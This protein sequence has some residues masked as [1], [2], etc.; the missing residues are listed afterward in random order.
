ML[1]RLAT[2]SDPQIDPTPISESRLPYVSGPRWK[3]S[4]TNTGIYVRIGMLRKVI[5]NAR[6][7]RPTID[8][9]TPD[10]A[11]ALLE[12]VVHRFLGASRA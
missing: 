4:F 5:R 3:M 8:S 2:P 1:P 11:D 7:M 6:M 9:V 10:E 12:A